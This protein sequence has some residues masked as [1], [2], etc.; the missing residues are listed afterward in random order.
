MNGRIIGLRFDTELSASICSEYMKKIFKCLIEQ[1]SATYD[2]LLYPYVDRLLLSREDASGCCFGTHALLWGFDAKT[3]AGAVVSACRDRLSELHPV[4]E[5]LD[6][7]A[8]ALGEF[9]SL[10]I[11][12]GTQ[13]E[14]AVGD[15]AS[16]LA[17]NVRPW[18]VR[19][20]SKRFCAFCEQAARIEGITE[21]GLC[22]GSLMVE[23]SDESAKEQIERLYTAKTGGAA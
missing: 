14:I 2:L 6:S 16:L 12:N 22:G 13:S 19:E 10:G 8:A 11:D 17:G 3:L 7:N 5:E 1:K 23:A 18:S 15:Y 4:A 9:L 21:K 20:A